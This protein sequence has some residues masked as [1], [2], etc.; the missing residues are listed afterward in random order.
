[1]NPAL[2]ITTETET[3]RC[4]EKMRCGT[5]RYD[6]GGGG[7]NVARVIQALGGTATAVFP[8]GGTAGTH[9]LELLR[10]RDSPAWPVWTDRPT[11]ESFTV[12]ELSTGKQYRFVLPGP[13]MTADDQ[14]RCLN[15]LR[16]A[17]EGAR[18]VVASGSLAP[19]LSPDLYQQVA[20]LC[21][22]LG[23][24]LILDTS[25]R[26]LRNIRS[27]VFMLKA[28][29]REIEDLMGR[30]LP[31]DQTRVTAAREIIDRGITRMVL[32]SCGAAGALLVR[33]DRAQRCAAV[34]V[35][36]RSGVGAGDA[37]VAAVV[38]GLSR[39]WSMEESMRLG[40][41]AGAAM[42]LTPGTEVCRIEDVERL[43]DT[44]PHPEAIEVQRRTPAS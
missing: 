5:A 35:T 2:D 19:G 34:P 13:A 6:P 41:A 39:D 9:I 42:T 27:N 32:M 38:T 12:N 25:G 37:M 16:G 28:S 29:V 20:E 18:Y 36:G 22:T 33:A 4:T 10:R 3:V 31:D 15:A 8:A 23:V 40:I 1:M 21:S 30:E 14:E 26:G 24:S 11:R 43:F 44:A 17:A 7:I